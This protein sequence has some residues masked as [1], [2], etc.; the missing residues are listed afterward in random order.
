MQEK[1]L[2]MSGRNWG[3]A[4]VD[5][6]TL[7]FNVAGKPAFRIPLTDVGQ[8][9]CAHACH[10]RILCRHLLS[11]IYTCLLAMSLK[12]W[13]VADGTVYLAALLI[14]YMPALLTR[15]NCSLQVTLVGSSQL[16]ITGLTTRPAM[17]G[18]VNIPRS[19]SAN[20][21]CAGSVNKVLCL[22]GIGAAACFPTPCRCRRAGMMSCWSSLLT[23]Q[24]EATMKMPC[25]RC[26]S[27]CPKRATGLEGKRPH[28]Q[29]RCEDSCF[30]PQAPRV[31]L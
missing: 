31:Q 27:M 20:R 24:Q 3:D 28:Q 25:A 19:N 6:S 11:H 4:V 1:E 18:L 9:P 12:K 8:V 23:T 2:S 13:H 7:V 17:Y 16:L 5:G 10:Q 26:R 30:V 15:S 14:H 22:H 29:R 21:R